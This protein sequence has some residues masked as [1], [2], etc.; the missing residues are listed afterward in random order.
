MTIT[1]YTFIDADGNEYG[2]FRTRDYGEAKSYAQ[3]NALMVVANEYEFTDSYPVPG[4][5]Y[6]PQPDTED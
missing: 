2:S 1:V 5:D 3:D 4:D 6:R